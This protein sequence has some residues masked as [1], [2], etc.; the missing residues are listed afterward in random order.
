MQHLAVIDL[1]SN[2]VRLA[3][4]E[5]K[6]DGSFK[7]IIERK[8]PVRLSENMGS[9][10]ILK[11]PA[12]DRTIK[13]LKSFKENF[14]NLENVHL[15]AMA[16]AATRM[17]KNQKEFLEE[18]KSKTDI[19]LEVIPG[20]TEAYYDYLGVINSLPV[21]NGIIMDTGGASTELVLIQ[22]RQAINMISLPFGSVTLSEGNIDPNVPTAG[23]MFKTLD[24]LNEI[25][26]DIWWLSRGTNLPIIGLGGS[27]RTLAKIKRRRDKDRKH[28]DDI[29]GFHLSN[30]E[31][32][33]IFL[34]LLNDNLEE[35]KLVPGVSKERADIIVGGLCPAME[36]M[37]RLNSDRMIFGKQGLR[38]GVLYEHLDNLRSS[39]KIQQK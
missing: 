19:D 36:M 25:F 11:Q 3:V 31:A 17:A 8:E 7:N 2:S 27:N 18:V 33:D 37:R 21:V 35:R 39:G 30:R 13:T 9:E 4:T 15:R 12:I 24:Y 16:T 29:H 5:I 14:E 26:N 22:N 28:W 20:T 1:G 38:Y 10:M 32:K 23:Q 34:M 6:E